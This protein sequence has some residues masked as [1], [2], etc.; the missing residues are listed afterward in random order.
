MNSNSITVVIPTFKRHALLERCLSRLAPYVRSHPECT[1]VISDNADASETS[2]KLTDYLDVVQVVQG[3][4]TSPAANRNC[5]AAH[6]TGSLIVFLDDDCIPEPDLIAA[7]RDAEIKNPE[8]GIFEGRISARGQIT[9]FADACPANETGGNLW[10]C[11]F[12]IRRELFSSVGGFDERFALPGM[13]DVDLRFRLSGK[14]P[15]LFIPEAR[16]FHDI[17]HRP[18]WK[19]QKHMALSTILYAHLRGLKE[20]GK[21]PAHVAWGMAHLAVHYSRQVWRREYVRD[22]QHIVMVLWVNT[23]IFCITL[24]WK[25]HPRLTKIIFPACCDG[26]RSIH[27]A[28]LE[29]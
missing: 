22:P 12:A 13:E 14:S 8:I 15:I 11:N 19:A 1:I 23:L 2:G 16:V 18:G 3:P 5:G 4:R 29:N 6:A 9:S 28:L 7:Y 27:T 10:S 17:E 25:F 21:N 26:C 24:L 20:T